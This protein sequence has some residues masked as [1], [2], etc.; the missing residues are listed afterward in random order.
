MKGLYSSPLRVYL[1]LGAL[2]LAGIIA[3]LSLP[4]SLF[5]NSSKPRVHVS[6]SYGSSTASEFLDVYG[7]NLREF[8]GESSPTVSR[9]RGSKRN[10][11]VRNVDYDIYF[12]WGTQPRAALREV[13]NALNAYGARFPIEV[14]DSVNT[15]I[16]Q[17]NGGFLWVSFYSPKR[18]LDEV[19]ELIE[20]IIGPQI[21]KVPDAEGQDSGIW[22]P[23]D[24]E[25][26]IELNPE[27]MAAL[28]LVPR[29]VDKAVN[30]ALQGNS[31]GAVTVGTQQLSIQ[32]PWLAQNIDDLGRT[33][34]S[35]P[36]GQAVH[37]SDIAKIDFSPKTTDTRSYKTSGRAEHF[38]V[39]DA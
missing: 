32:M 18:S 17:D 39:G 23:S 37:L 13:Q 3:G 4:V 30:F 25:I 20:P 29:D 21:A 38:L 10:Y 12:K 27:K 24:K 2:A 7:R 15:W 14:R 16:N 36:G 5:P 19:Y 35:T 9:S 22:N 11:D 33:V 34:V 8:S 26:R 6:I 28:Q 31:G 1:C